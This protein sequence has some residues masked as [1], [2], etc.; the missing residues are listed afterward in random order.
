TLARIAFSGDQPGLIAALIGE[1]VVPNPA[2][3]ASG[4]LDRILAQARMRAAAPLL[5]VSIENRGRADAT[6][7]T[8]HYPK[9]GE[10]GFQSFVFDG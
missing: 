4:S 3:A 1:R 6:V 8:R 10:L 9:A 2:A 5:S 7:L